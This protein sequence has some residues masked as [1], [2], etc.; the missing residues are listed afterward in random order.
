VR[1]ALLNR[2]TR[3]GQ[4]KTNR[5]QEWRKSLSKYIY[6]YI[7]IYIFICIYI[8]LHA[9]GLSDSWGVRTCHLR[10]YPSPPPPFPQNQGIPRKKEGIKER[11][12]FLCS[13]HR[14]KEIRKGKAKQEAQAEKAPTEAAKKAEANYLL[15][16]A[17]AVA[18]V[19]FG[20][21]VANRDKNK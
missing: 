17:V 10:C 2:P 7:Y 5:K 1:S 21:A 6:I 8:Y 3:E 15:Y 11:K 19:A 4:N 13:L 14:K 18:L 20:L 9:R 16:G 12:A